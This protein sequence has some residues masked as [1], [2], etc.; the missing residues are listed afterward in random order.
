MKADWSCTISAD[1]FEAEQGILYLMLMHV[2]LQP[3]HLAILFNN[4]FY[5][6]S[7]RKVDIAKSSETIMG[8][9]HRKQIPSLMIKFTSISNQK[10]ENILV[11][12]FSRY[13]P[14]LNHDNITCLAPVRNVLE[15]IFHIQ[16]PGNVVFDLL[17]VFDANNLIDDVFGLNTNKGKFTLSRYTY[18]DVVEQI[19]ILKN[20]S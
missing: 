11:K 12:E 4:K 15:L 8:V 1:E 20:L 6:L 5:S 17:N 10:I 7:T 13:Q 2:N 19:K 9:I 16:I 18:E 14:L 3:A